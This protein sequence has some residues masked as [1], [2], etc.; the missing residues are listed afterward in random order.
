MLPY[1]VKGYLNTARYAFDED[2]D[3]EEEEEDLE[4]PAGLRPPPNRFAHIKGTASST[5]RDQLQS[6]ST[7]TCCKEVHQRAAGAEAP[8]PAPSKSKWVQ[9][10]AGC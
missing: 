3:E 6:Q 4:T 1:N 2:T 7:D 10:Q 8:L 9:A 5:E